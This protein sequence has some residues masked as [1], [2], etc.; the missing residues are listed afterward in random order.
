M[1]IGSDNIPKSPPEVSEQG[2]KVLARLAVC[3]RGTIECGSTDKV[4]V[5]QCFHVCVGL[6]WGWEPIFMHCE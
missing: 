5:L 1:F 6:F 3:S 2:C 4:L